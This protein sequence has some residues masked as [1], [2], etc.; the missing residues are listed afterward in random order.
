MKIE[1]VSIEIQPHDSPETIHKALSLLSP[2]EQPQSLS[3]V[4]PIPKAPTTPDG[5][6]SLSPTAVTWILL[7]QPVAFFILI[8]LL[9]AA[10]WGPGGYFYTP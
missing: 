1:K 9:R 4:E 3:W 7:F 10:L 6:I 8:N 2:Q 5:K